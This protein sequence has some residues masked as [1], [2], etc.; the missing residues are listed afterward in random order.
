MA[1]SPF[2]L[3]IETALRPPTNVR[4]VAKQ[5]ATQLGN[6]DIGLS[7]NSI[8]NIAKAE[9][10]LRSL[11]ST[12]KKVTSEFKILGAAAAETFQRFF[13]F[14]IIISQMYA[15]AGAIKS[16]TKEAIDFDKE[17]IKIKQV[18][19]ASS[20]EI[21]S[22]ANQVGF[23]STKFGVSSKELLNAS[24]IFAQ[25]GLS[26]KDTQIAISTLALTDL[27]P[28]FKN[29]ANSAETAIAIMS[30]FKLEAKDLAGAFES[31]DAVSA[32]F[33]VEAEDLNIVIRRA[34]G[35]FEAAG[36]SL[37]ELLALF[38]SVR[39]T[40]RES[41][42]SIST[43]LRTIFARLQRPKTQSFLE[44]LGIT[45][46]D[47]GEFKGPLEAIKQISNAVKD[48][49]KNDI[50]FAGLVE[51]LGGVRQLS[52]VIPLIKEYGL[53]QEA[54]I[55]AETAQGRLAQNAILA[56]QSLAN[57][58]EKTKESFLDLARTVSSDTGFQ[59]LIRNLLLTA[60][61]TADVAKN[62]KGLI[63]LLITAAGGIG[64]IKGGEFASGFAGRL[65]FNLGG[66]GQKGGFGALN[67]QNVAVAGGGAALGLSLLSTFGQLDD[68]SK[69]LVNTFAGLGA[70]LFALQGALA[71][72]SQQK[73]A[74][75]VE[76]AN[77][78]RTNL[79]STNEQLAANST[80]FH[81]FRSAIAGLGETDD[82][83]ILAQTAKEQ[84]KSRLS[85]LRASKNPSLKNNFTDE[86]QQ[87]IDVRARQKVLDDRLGV[88]VGETKE[89]N[90]L[91]IKAHLLQDAVN[92]KDTTQSI[93]IADEADR[94][95]AIVKEKRIIS[96]NA[97]ILS[98][99][100]IADA[101]K[102]ELDASSKITQAR[103]KELSDRKAL[104][105]KEIAATERLVRN[106]ELANIGVSLLATLAAGA[107]QFLSQSGRSQLETGNTGGRNNFVAGSAFQSAATGAGLGALAG[108]AVLPGIGTAV[109]AGIGG[110]IGFGVGLV[111]GAH[112]A[113][114]ILEN[115]RFT[116]ATTELANILKETSAGRGNPLFSAGS[117]TSTVRQLRQSLAT[118]DTADKSE[119]LAGI[120]N[121]ITP[122]TE[123]ANQIAKTSTSLDEFKSKLSPEVF[124][125][126]ADFGGTTVKNLEKRFQELIDATTKLKNVDEEFVRIQ[127]RQFERLVEVNNF[128]SAIEDSVNSIEVFNSALN[129]TSFG[130]KSS[131]FSRTTS[132]KNFGNAV[133]QVLSPFGDAGR[134]LAQE[135]K[136]IQGV[137]QQ[138]PNVLLK[139]SKSDPF[140]QGSDFNDKL[141]S[142]LSDIPAF[143]R[144]AIVN[145]ADAII[146]GDEKDAKIIDAITHDLSGT[147]NKLTSG[148][149]EL[150]QPLSKIN[151]AITT[152]TNNLIDLSGKSR[153]SSAQGR[154]I[155][156]RSVDISEQR[157]R[158]GASLA[159]TPFI[160]TG[161]F[162]RQRRSQVLGL[163]STIPGGVTPTSLFGSSKALTSSIEQKRLEL[164]STV[165][166][167]SRTRIIKELNK[168]EEALAKVNEGLDFLSDAAAR[169]AAPLEELARLKAVRENRADLTKQL[170][171]GD[172]ETRRSIRRNIAGAAQLAKTG[173][174]N[175]ISPTDRQGVLGILEKFGNDKRFGGLTGKEVIQKT[176]DKL[177]LG[178]EF[179][180]TL[181][182]IKKGIEATEAFNTAIE[183]NNLKGLTFEQRTVELL[184]R[185]DKNT[186][187]FNKNIQTNIQTGINNQLTSKRT[188]LLAS[189][190]AL[191]SQIGARNNI[192]EQLLPTGRQF[193]NAGL[194][195]IRKSF[196]QLQELRI[197]QQRQ[198]SAG[199][200]RSIL[201]ENSTLGV[202]LKSPD[203]GF[204]LS[205][206]ELDNIFKNLEN[207]VGKEFA[208][209]FR[210]KVASS[211]QINKFGGIEGGAFSKGGG[212]GDFNALLES[213]LKKL[214]EQGNLD[215]KIFEEKSATVQQNLGIN[216]LQPLLE[217][218]PKIQE[219]F[220]L[221]PAN[222]EK[223]D[224]E[225]TNLGLQLIEVNKSLATNF[226]PELFE[227]FNKTVTDMGKAFEA[228]P[229]S[230]DITGGQK[231]EV[232]FNGAEVFKNLEPVMTTL[233][234]AK[235]GKAINDL[236]KAKFPGVGGFNPA[237]EAPL[238]VGGGKPISG[239]RAIA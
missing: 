236:L 176:A 100:A 4:S 95:A 49:P 125:F 148:F 69:K 5:I 34:G 143:I 54:L 182:E 186:E 47:N 74:G 238:K 121:A 91:R 26:I 169:T 82:T 103:I 70:Q 214:V 1:N 163:G 189:S 61:T 235:I 142:E 201:S 221:L 33:A 147:V 205:K 53:A 80:K 145:Q 206:S 52:K 48:L 22:L 183:A 107:G 89:R 230:I 92:T 231:I 239:D 62:L 90:K 137:A 232:I 140:G 11:G 72:S 39:A 168:E 12:S 171:F 2:I 117:V 179:R 23:L 227:M 37:N 228:L 166:V 187:E 132:S 51:E 88:G 188:N 220:K 173:D 185:I 56:Q 197:I 219:Q 149:N 177:G 76:Q 213:E 85:K 42:E 175:T 215:K 135:A 116:K 106:T 229:R 226:T 237:K 97:L 31:I 94:K 151:E 158:L 14:T 63:P 129:G 67:Q 43:A 7:Q 57:Q 178:D 108:S 75:R 174:I 66:K 195:N 112:E 16:A 29:M 6:L 190:Q 20:D 98:N 87:L 119:R 44:T 55:V 136:A 225:F 128:T 113:E 38:T 234:E 162:E 35:A 93:L 224:S 32:K 184:A 181:E 122:L 154:A 138:L 218:L 150:L 222:L 60:S 28:T 207:T 81:E 199:A 46:S 161:I 8:N 203:E 118:A 77:V 17:L 127:E 114:R 109:G 146:G 120:N 204:T 216:N 10:G 164:Q 59:G 167:D 30:Q 212:T 83:K 64:L 198:K 192:V 79:L 73:L 78:A 71:F 19:G 102:K 111:Q 156:L 21:K 101:K 40:T 123:F 152:F 233:I 50:R 104:L 159:D 41:A 153:E 139:L 165:D 160:N 180:P 131:T 25:A 157:A 13:G 9:A 210:T 58:L 84:A 208:D 115:V 211:L 124:D 194:E 27:S 200:A 193:D 99:A 202:G 110:G 15:A 170:I 217:S 68:E 172:P 65:G 155:R 130:G 24:Q 141:R 126:L 18:S 133:D 96:E 3:S 105:S 209:S 144:E 86:E 134:Q 191:G 45:T 36:G 223:M 196:T